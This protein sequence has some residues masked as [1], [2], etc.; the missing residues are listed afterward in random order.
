M[1]RRSE[2]A[3]ALDF[4][5]LIAQAYR[6][7][8]TFP[9]VAL[10]YRRAYAYWM[11]DEFQDTTDGQY[12]LIKAFAGRQIPQ[13]LRG[14]RRRP[15][16]LSVERRELQANPAVSGRFSASR[17]PASHQLSLPAEH[18]RG[19]KSAGRAQHAADASKQPL[20]AGKTTLLYP[21]DSTSISCAIRRRR[22]RRQRS[23]LAFPGYRSKR[24]EMAVLAR[25]RALLERMNKASTMQGCRSDGT[26]P[27]RFSVAAIPVAGCSVR[28]AARP[29]TG[30]P[31][32]R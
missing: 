1:R 12:R 17:N 6:L 9:G 22:P 18:R 14:R 23:R 29:W 3:N 13:Y 31:W 25:T 11:F 7:I 19:S 28:L 20:E 4:G 5:S 2:S 10:H 8:S 30:G 32:I 21:M 26:A 15:D 24:G 27:G 16:H